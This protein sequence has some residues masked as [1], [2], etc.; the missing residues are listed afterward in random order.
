MNNI[1]I[2]NCLVIPMSSAKAEIFEAS[3][4][5]RDG[6]ITM[7]D[8]D[9]T[10]A[11]QFIAESKGEVKQINAK[12]KVL[13]PGLINTHGHVSMTLMR[14]YGDDMQLMPWLIE[15]IWPLEAKLTG[16]D[17]RLGAELGIAEMLLGG[18]TC[19]V[20]MYW[21]EIEVGKAVDK[22]GIRAVL[23]PTFVDARF[24]E[25]VADFNAVVE[26]YGNH[27]RVMIKV[28][29][30][31][32][33]TCCE[34]NVKAAVKMARD[35][36]LGIHI[37]VAETLDEIGIIRERYDRTPVELLRDWGVL[38]S[39]VMSVHSVHLTD[40]DIDIL[41]EFGVS[42]V[43]NPQSNMKLSSGSAPVAKMIEKGINVSIGTDGASSNNDL[44]MWEE[45]RSASFQQKLA[46]MNPCVLPAYDVLRM[47]TYG[48]AKAIG[49]EGKLG[50]VVE[51]AVADLIL[52]DIS[53]PHYFPR[54]DIIANL[55]YCGKSSDVDSVIVGGELV[56]EGGKLLTC[57]MAKLC[58]EV[59]VAVDSLL[60]R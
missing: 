51:G 12:G 23:S 34:E 18:T 59:Q 13:M 47:A 14:G 21:Q 22:L 46:S 56:V 26:S 28:A 48:G 27:P 58:A 31:S 16:D 1:L 32:V 4:G 33:Y 11:E 43:N 57:D 24:D 5:V 60:K 2:K 39:D 37:H 17:I 36:N 10:R 55:A 54:H 7:V 8:C 44:D 52:M 53:K 3:V 6:K 19:F 29:P 30:H 9:G 40:A 15:R 35:R 41:K 50:V 49:M 38:G 45:L 20:D 42:A 25:F